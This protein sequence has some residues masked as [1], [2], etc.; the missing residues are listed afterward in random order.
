M[1]YI[2]C[3]AHNIQL[4]IKDG[5]KLDKTYIDLINHV[6]K[7]IVSKSKTSLLIAEELRKLDKKLNMKNV[8]RWNSIL[9]MIRSVLKLTPEDIKS[10]QGSMPA[11]NAKQKEIKKKFCLTSTE[12]DMLSELK[13]LLEMFEFVT[14]ELQSN[15]I[16]IS[17]VYPAVAMLKKKF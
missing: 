6:S 3:A 16:N 4:V 5:L 11:Q 9:F 8:T 10:I 7:D 14:D 1:A 2:P 15:K 13:D 12:R 17:R